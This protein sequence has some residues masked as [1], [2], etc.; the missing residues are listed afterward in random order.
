MITVAAARQRLSKMY[1]RKYS[2][3]AVEPF[4]AN[5]PV[6]L[7]LQPPTDTQVSGDMLAVG[8]WLRG[9]SQVNTA[10][11]HV[12]WETRRWPNSG[13][14][15]V[16]VRFEATSPAALAGFLTQDKH[17]AVHQ[18]R[19]GRLLLLSPTSDPETSVFAAAVSKVLPKA[20]LLSEHDFDRV[21]D[22][23]AWLEKNPISGIFPRQL[24]VE[25]ID[26]KW[27]E[28]HQGIIRPLHLA[29][30]GTADL[31][32]NA[33]PKL[34]RIRF[35]DRAL[36]PGGLDD[37]MAPAVALAQLPIS[38]HTVLILENL[39]TLLS[40]PDMDSVVALHGAGYDVRW[41]AALPW[42]RNARVLYWGD[43][44]ADGLTILSTLRSVLPQVESVMM[45]E[46][47][48]HRFAHLA[49]SDPNGPGS[50]APSGLT[51]E[52]TAVFELLRQN[53]GLRLEQERID[54]AHALKTIG[55][56]LAPARN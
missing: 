40:L 51:A 54:W 13:T 9:W 38:P 3:W 48:L 1:Q 33:A 11:I 15:R 34:Y 49:V 23:L 32:L 18:Q 25:G 46:A 10:G 52:E 7:G 50:I 56:V 21:F 53:G 12:T 55:R 28:R 6:T 8:Q 39:Q 45:D 31:G 16:P 30:G 37:L 43:L 17:F 47:T 14:Q 20:G 41:S 26:S 24:P 2:S 22:V 5:T 44:D 19:A 35:L 42:V 4:D 27:L 36:A 29:L